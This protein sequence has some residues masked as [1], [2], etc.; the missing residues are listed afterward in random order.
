MCDEQKNLQSLA[1]R[2]ATDIAQTV[3]KLFPTV[4]DSLVS[5]LCCVC[6]WE[7]NLSL[8]PRNYLMLRMG[9]IISEGLCL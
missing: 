1:A 3:E 2:V 5:V 7:I 6:V 8:L 9:T 4:G